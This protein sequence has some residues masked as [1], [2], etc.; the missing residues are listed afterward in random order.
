MKTESEIKPDNGGGIEEKKGGSW[1]EEYHLRGTAGDEK[2]SLSLPL[3]VGYDQRT[4]RNRFR[5]YFSK[6][7]QVAA[8]P[9]AYRRLSGIAFLQIYRDVPTGRKQPVRRRISA[10]CYNRLQEAGKRG[11]V[12]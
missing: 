11:G 8:F 12:Q 9:K 10:A 3:I 4:V 1:D 2:I 6:K 5:K 7:E